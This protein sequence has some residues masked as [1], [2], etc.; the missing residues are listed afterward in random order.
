M[1][2]Y[3]NGRQHGSLFERSDDLVSI[4]GVSFVLLKAMNREKYRIC[5]WGSAHRD[6]VAFKPT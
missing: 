5:W 6:A 4:P 1:V 2:L 3:L